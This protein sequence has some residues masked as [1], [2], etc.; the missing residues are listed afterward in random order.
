[1]FSAHHQR[2]YWAR[3]MA[4]WRPFSKAQ[5][6]DGHSAL[7]ELQAMGIVGTVIT[8]NVD[9]LHQK[10]GAQDV[11][12]LHGRNDI[13]KCMACG[14]KKYRGGFQEELEARNAAWSGWKGEWEARADGDAAL[15]GAEEADYDS[16][17]VPHCYACGEGPMKPDVVFFGDRVEDAVKD[18][19]M[20][21]VLEQG[22]LLAVGTSMSTLSAFRLVQAAAD[23][24]KPLGVVNIGKTRLERKGNEAIA[25]HVSLY[26]EERCGEVLAKALELLKESEELRK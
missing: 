25:D 2:R 26:V 16:F 17:E 11:V 14:A 15:R 9:G 22:G 6:N 7:A 13:I 23:G 18:R 21:A 20:G 1:M 12:D 24:G 3:S 8:Q 5:P 10:A 19:A 4:G